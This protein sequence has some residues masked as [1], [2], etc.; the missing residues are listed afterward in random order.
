MKLPCQQILA[1]A[2]ALL[3]IPSVSQALDVARSNTL[4]ESACREALRLPSLPDFGERLR[5]LEQHDSRRSALDE[6]LA[7]LTARMARRYTSAG[8][9]A[10]A[11]PVQACIAAN[12]EARIDILML[13]DPA[14][15]R[16]DARNASGS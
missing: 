5:D 11:S 4:L 6:Y 13:D 3:L 12:P 7:L 8:P 1:L 15:H 14:H 10:G 2:L 16:V 9:P